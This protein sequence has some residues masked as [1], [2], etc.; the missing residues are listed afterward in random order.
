MIH[1]PRIMG[2][3][4]HSTAVGPLSRVHDVLLDPL[5][6]SGPIAATL[7]GQFDREVIG[8]ACVGSLLHAVRGY[9]KSRLCDRNL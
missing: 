3:F 9:E 6:P 2:F 4:A 8:K 1:T 7:G 5:T